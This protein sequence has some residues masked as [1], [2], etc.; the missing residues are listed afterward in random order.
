M[1][2]SSATQPSG[3]SVEERLAYLEA[4]FASG[5]AAKP[6]AEYERV[7]RRRLKRRILFYMLS[8]ALI[9]LVLLGVVE[10]QVSKAAILEVY[11]GQHQRILNELKA[12]YDNEVKR[13]KTQFEWSR[14]QRN[15]TKYASLAAFYVSENLPSEKKQQEIDK[16][17]SRSETYLKYALLADPHQAPSYYALGQLFYSCPKEYH[18]TNWVDF[19]KALSYYTKA[20]KYYPETEAAKRGD[21]YRMVGKVQC[22]RAQAAQG[23]RQAAELLQRAREALEKARD[24]YS[25]A[26]SDRHDRNHE[27]I[28]ALEKARYEY[29]RALSDRHDRNHEGI[30]ETRKLLL[31]ISTGQGC[32]AQTAPKEGSCTA[33]AEH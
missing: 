20:I 33:E 25:R 12:R 27:G 17:F 28:E 13:G 30:E 24:E 23:R 10:R 1:S 21:A 3:P 6:F 9:M 29:S 32:G 22:E 8:L 19:D 4:R 5:W 11:E 7:F 14:Q 18:Q 31:S 16:I 15:G 2:N 26:L